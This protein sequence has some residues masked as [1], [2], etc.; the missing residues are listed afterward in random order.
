MVQGHGQS[1]HGVL[2][3]M[4]TGPNFD[5]RLPGM[6][7]GGDPTLGCREIALSDLVRAS[8]GRRCG[9]C[10]HPM[11]SLENELN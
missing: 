9:S 8:E 2:W 7:W 5:E 10:V 6:V 3:G 1:A 4:R 11:F